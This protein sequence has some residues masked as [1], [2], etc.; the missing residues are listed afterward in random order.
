MLERCRVAVIDEIPFFG[1]GEVAHRER[2]ILGREEL[3]DF[4]QRPRVEF[5]FMPFALGVLR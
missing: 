3:F 1:H 5:S 2:G 4:R